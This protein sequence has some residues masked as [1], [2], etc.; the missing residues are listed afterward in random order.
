MYEK[1]PIPRAELIRFLGA[2]CPSPRCAG[3][4]SNNFALFE[5]SNIDGKGTVG[6]MAATG[7]PFP[8][9]D[10]T[11]AKAVDVVALACN[12]CGTLWQMFRPTV[13]AWFAQNPPQEGANDAFKPGDIYSE[14]N[15]FDIGKKTN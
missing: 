15:I 12:N 2:K 11:S 13:V 1:S 7:F 3:C 4:G 6:R 9:Y 5:E 8:D 14:A 10:I